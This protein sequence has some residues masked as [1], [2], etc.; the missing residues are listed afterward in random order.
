M[1]AFLRS[2]DQN[3]ASRKV[4]EGPRS[5][6]T[7]FVVTGCC[8]YA[9]AGPRQS[10]HRY[11]LSDL[12]AHQILSDFQRSVVGLPCLRNEFVDTR[13]RHRLAGEKD[14]VRVGGEPWPRHGEHG[15]GF[16]RGRMMRHDALDEGFREQ[17]GSYDRDFVDQEVNAGAVLDDVLIEARIARDDDGAAVILDAISVGRFDCAPWSTSKAITR[18]PL[19]SYTTPSAEN[20]LTSIA[21]PCAES[22]SSLVRMHTSSA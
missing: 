13:A 18:T 9:L 2:A 4:R 11:I 6:F 3:Q 14:K 7:Y 17:L 8:G 20:S 19:L 16:A 5:D 22:F 12:E 15:A 21:A 1:S 10:P